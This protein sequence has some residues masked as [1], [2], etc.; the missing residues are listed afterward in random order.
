MPH[1][2]PIS[3]L[4]FRLCLAFVLTAIIGLEREWYRKP[5]G[6][7][8][9][10]IVGV[11]SALF[12]LI[13]FRVRDL[14]P[15]ALVDPT[16]IAAQVVTGLGFLG[17]GTIIRAKG[18]IVGLTTAASIFIVAAIGMACGYGLYAEA[19]A[20]TILTLMAFFGLSVIVDFV[21][22]KSSIPSQLDESEH[23]IEQNRHIIMH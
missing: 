4:I 9:L 13:S 16:R 3:A 6:L 8:T 22:H 17:A 23:D 14:F 18:E 15:S 21:R 2:L 5:A 7:R 1:A 12:T 11:A 19:I 10:T 20:A